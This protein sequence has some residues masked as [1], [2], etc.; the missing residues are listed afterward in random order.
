MGVVGSILMRCFVEVLVWWWYSGVGVGV[1]S[2]CSD[3][4]L[5]VLMWW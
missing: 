1:L 4:M 5:G 2:W 3:V